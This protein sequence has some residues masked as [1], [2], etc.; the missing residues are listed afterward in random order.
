MLFARSTAKIL[1]YLLL[2]LNYG[3]ALRA[4]E[5]QTV[6]VTPVVTSQER[7]IDALIEAVHQATVS[8]QTSGRITKIHFDVDDYVSKG[9]VLLEFSAKSQRAAFNAA[10]YPPGPAPKMTTFI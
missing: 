10:T 7:T 9:D 5:L 8:A 4:A 6:T 2:L 3:Q 1:I